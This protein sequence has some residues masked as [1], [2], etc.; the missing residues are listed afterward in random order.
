MF[1]TFHWR[2]FD[3]GPIS[4]LGNRQRVNLIR[5]VP[6]PERSHRHGRDHL[7]LMTV[8]RCQASPVV[9]SGAGLKSDQI[10]LLVRQKLGKLD[11]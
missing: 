11:A 5:L 10:R 9:G 4:R 7:D 1:D 8:G 3:A 2:K 6:L